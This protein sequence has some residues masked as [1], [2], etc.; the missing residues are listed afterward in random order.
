MRKFLIIM[1]MSV[2]MS[3]GAVTQGSKAQRVCAAFASAGELAARSKNDDLPRWVVE[4]LW[5]SGVSQSV[6]PGLR[7]VANIVGRLEI[8]SVYQKGITEP[9]YGYWDG[10]NVCMEFFDVY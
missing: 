9:S 3:A 5:V 10:Y 6:A 4:N 8:N 1:L 7:A 2:S